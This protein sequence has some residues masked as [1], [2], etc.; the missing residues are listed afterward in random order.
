MKLEKRNISEEMKL[1]KWIVEDYGTLK[2]VKDG[3]VIVKEG[4]KNVGMSEKV[5]FAGKNK[6]G[7]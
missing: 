6:K 3:V 5:E 1:E 7:C 4:L 2:E